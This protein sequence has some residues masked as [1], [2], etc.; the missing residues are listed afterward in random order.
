MPDSANRY[1][2]CSTDPGVRCK[3]TPQHRDNKAGGGPNLGP[4]ANTSPALVLCYR[5]RLAACLHL[6]TGGGDPVL[7]GKCMC[8]HSAITFAAVLV[9]WWLAPAVP[10]QLRRYSRKIV[11]GS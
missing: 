3:R 2:A 9:P 7:A 1:V 4:A 6:S 8:I 11:A 10:T 5:S